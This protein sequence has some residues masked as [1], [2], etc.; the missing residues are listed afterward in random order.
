MCDVFANQLFEAEVRQIPYVSDSSCGL[1][2]LCHVCPLISIS[3]VV[4][5]RLLC[6]GDRKLALQWPQTLQASGKSPK[7]TV[8]AMV[9][10]CHRS[11]DFN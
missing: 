2:H 5:G 1:V 11:L 8:T 9:L 4:G 7:G 3:V 6:L 10:L